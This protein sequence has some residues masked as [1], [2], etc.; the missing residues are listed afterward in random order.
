M[1]NTIKSFYNSVEWQRLRLR[2]I[3]ERGMNNNGKILCEYCGREIKDTNEVEVDHIKELTLDNVNNYNVSLSPDNL[4]VSCHSCHNKKH[5]RFVSKKEQQVYIVYGPPLSGKKTYVKEHMVR[6]DLIVDMDLL[7]YALS[8][9]ELYDK[10]EVL[11]YNVF[12][13]KNLLLDNIKTRYGKFRNA[14]IIGGYPNKHDRERMAKDL[15]AELIYIRASKEECLLNLALCQDTR[16]H[17]KSKWEGFID[18][19]FEEY[20]E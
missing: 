15:R 3:A 14:W 18:K 19:W 5:D 20:Q 4:K 17:Q 12:A 11:K 7:F 2:V 10:P 16:R 1:W 13:V 6:G 8:L 9:F